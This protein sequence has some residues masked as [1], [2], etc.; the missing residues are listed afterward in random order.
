MRKQ[1]S[2]FRFSEETKGRLV[3]LAAHNGMSRAAVLESLIAATAETPE[4]SW[5]DR[6]DGELR[7][8]ADDA[9]WLCKQI[10]DGQHSVGFA[11]AAAETNRLRFDVV[12]FRLRNGLI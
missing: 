12:E 7:S 1:I 11:T 5:R 9:K 2:S 10:G 4:P 3:E 8:I 6:L